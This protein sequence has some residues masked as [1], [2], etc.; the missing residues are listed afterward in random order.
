MADKQQI[1]AK[2]KRTLQRALSAWWVLLIIVVYSAF[3]WWFTGTSCL[4]ASTTGM[5][6]PGCGGTRAF[7]ALL[8]GDITG[9]LRNHPLLI[10]SAAIMGAYF[11][12]RLIKDRSQDYMKKILIALLIALAATYAIRMIIMF[13]ETPPLKYN[14]QAIL[15]RIIST[16]IPGTI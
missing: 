4:I 12:G 13:P 7:L 16:I 14:D 3:A 11:I 10:P 9:S 1:T 6:C 15:P 5:P 8:K 2:I